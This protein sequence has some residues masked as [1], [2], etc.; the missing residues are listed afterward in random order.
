MP[1]RVSLDIFDGPL[2][3][4]LHLIRRRELDVCDV[5]LA[6]VTESY[7]QHVEHLRRQGGVDLEDVGEFLVVAATLIEIKSAGLLPR[8]E[9]RRMAEEDSPE[10][11]VDPRVEL[12]RQLLEYKKYKE[13]AGELEDLREV[14][15]LQYPRV[16]AKRADGDDEP[17]PLELEEL[18]AWDLLSIFERLMDE[19]GRRGPSQHEVAD[20]ETP[21]RLH[22]ADLADRVRRDRRL[23]LRRVLV[24]CGSR[25]EMIGLFL[26]L[27]ELVRQK[28]VLVSVTEGGEDLEITEA[29]PEHRA[30]AVEADTEFEEDDYEP[31]ADES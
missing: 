11:T 29:P 12:V 15:S 22:A 25:R 10:E 1:Y 24:G 9:H 8:P 14:A 5:A 28:R 27:L 7:L 16:P 31:V 30:T 19:V 26:A 3:L 4:L 6:E 13:A 21:I 17:P 18:H 20:D 2:D 23:S